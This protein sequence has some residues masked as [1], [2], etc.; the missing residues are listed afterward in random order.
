MKTLLFVVLVVAA[1]CSCLLW[2][3][4]TGRITPS[5]WNFDATPRHFRK[6]SSQEQVVRAHIVSLL[7]DGE[8]AWRQGDL[9]TAEANFEAV[10][11]D[12]S[13][14]FGKSDYDKKANSDLAALH[15]QEGHK[16]TPQILRI[17]VKPPPAPSNGRTR[18][19]HG[20]LAPPLLGAR[21]TPTGR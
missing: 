14:F 3:V 16:V 13:A 8:Y 17:H 11:N 7:A 1:V 19:E 10:I 20:S 15:K 2:V 12:R 5:G 4:L 21:G 6:S 9:K 18:Q